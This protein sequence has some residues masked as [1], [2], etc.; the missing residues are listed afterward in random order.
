MSHIFFE[1]LETRRSTQS[2]Y[3]G[4]GYSAPNPYIQG[5]YGVGI[6]PY[7]GYPPIGGYPNSISSYPPY[8]PSGGY[9]PS[10]NP[11]PNW[12]N[13]Y[14]SSWMS[15]FPNLWGGMG[16]WFSPVW[17]MFQGWFGGQPSYWGPS[18]WQ[19]PQYWGPSQWFTYP[20]PN[21]YSPPQPSTYYAYA[22]GIPT[23]AM[24]F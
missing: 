8:Y 18:Q 13:P 7:E 19:Q 20:Y 21:T 4:W 9:Y 3:G 6:N 1:R 5:Y 24:L 17:N 14:P 2:L 10:Y 11:Y 22:I 15:P 12:Y 16:S 23:G